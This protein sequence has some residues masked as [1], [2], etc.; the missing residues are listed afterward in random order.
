MVM[1]LLKQHIEQSVQTP[2]WYRQFDIMPSRIRMVGTAAVAI[3]SGRM[4]VAA[5]RAQRDEYYDAVAELLNEQ[6]VR[7]GN[8]LIDDNLP[9]Q[10][11]ER[12]DIDTVVVHHTHRAEGITNDRLNAM[13]LVRLYI[14]RFRSDPDY[15]GV[16]LYSG[17]FDATGKQVFYPYH[18][19]VKQDGEVERLLD[20]EEIGWHAG[21]WDINTRSVAI[22][23][24]DNLRG[25]YPSESAVASAR[26]IIGEYYRHTRIIGHTE[27][28]PA[29]DCPGD[30]FFGPTGWQSGLR[31]EYNAQPL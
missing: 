9:D 18:W 11:A 1:E 23:I 27:V 31:S 10:D 2:E 17:H 7:L 26:D 16:P 25:K 12:R 4:P 28:N 30:N 5:V 22:C 19:M 24:D 6:K 13:E 20:D 8:P 21:D 14:P 29:T 3:V 15:V